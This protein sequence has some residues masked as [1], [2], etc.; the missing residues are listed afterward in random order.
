MTL[1]CSDYS[2]IFWWDYSSYA[3]YDHNTIIK[4][5]KK[6]KSFR[7]STHQSTPFMISLATFYYFMNNL[8]LLFF[9]E[10]EPFIW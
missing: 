7:E 9:I 8:L 10:F 4:D 6:K 1:S 2:S 3:I 5:K